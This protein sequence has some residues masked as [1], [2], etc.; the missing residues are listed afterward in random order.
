MF[1][2]AGATVLLS[3][4]NTSNGAPLMPTTDRS[5]ISESENQELA[6]ESVSWLLELFPSPNKKTSTMSP[7]F[8]FKIPE[9]TQPKE[10]LATGSATEVLETRK[11]PL[12]RI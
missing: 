7:G 4:D 6:D 3:V 2:A 12:T 5:G 9:A 11:T 8:K 10:R 1:C